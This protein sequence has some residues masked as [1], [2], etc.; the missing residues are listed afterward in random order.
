MATEIPPFG[1]REPNLTFERARQ[2]PRAAQLNVRPHMNPRRMPM[3]VKLL[4]AMPCSLVGV[5]L[6]ILVICLGGSVRRVGHTLEVALRLQHAH[7]PP[8]A[9]NFRFAG[10]TLGH[11]IV[12]QSHEVLTVL[13]AHERVHV[14]QYERLGLLFFIAYP[15]S[16]L[17]ALLR[18]QCPYRDN[19]F[20]QEACRSVPAGEGAA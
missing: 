20:E 13:R 8:W 18:G 14:K 4:W 2:K 11:V 15:V 3:F 1:R 6:G 16:S 19:R 7:L 17:V 10:I 9:S 5:A 12:G